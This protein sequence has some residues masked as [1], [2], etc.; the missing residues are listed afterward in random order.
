MKYL[1][2]LSIVITGLQVGC[3]KDGAKIIVDVY[4][5]EKSTGSTPTGTFDSSPLDLYLDGEYLGTTPVTFRKSDL[6]RLNLPESEW[7]EISSTQ[8]WYTWDLGRTNGTFGIA[9]KQDRINK[10]TL[11]FRSRD[12]QN[13]IPVAFSGFSRSAREDQPLGGVVLLARFPKAGEAE[14]AGGPK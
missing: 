11:E 7:V 4:S 12:R 8:G 9:H 13:P 3:T 6:E 5:P 14:H 1:A 10:R 2:L